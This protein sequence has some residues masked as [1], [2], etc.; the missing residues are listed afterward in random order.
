MHSKRRKRSI[1][2][3]CTNSQTVQWGNSY[4]FSQKNLYTNG[5]QDELKGGHRYFISCSQ[6]SSRFRDGHRTAYIPSG[7]RD[8]DLEKLFRGEALDGFDTPVPCGR[9]VPAH[10]GSKVTYCST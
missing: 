7:L 10:I 8:E 1:M 9:I 6:W 5:T 2:H 3:G 4:L